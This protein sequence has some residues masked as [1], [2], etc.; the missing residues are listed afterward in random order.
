MTK[1][2]LE[3]TYR[4]ISQSGKM[5][6]S[7]RN[8]KALKRHRQVHEEVRESAYG[9]FTKA[10]AS[11]VAL[12]FAKKDKSE[13]TT[14]PKL[15]SKSRFARSNAIEVRTRS[16]ETVKSGVTV[17]RARATLPIIDSS[18]HQHIQAR[19]VADGERD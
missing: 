19:A 7:F 6:G 18:T 4:P 17:Q 2:E 8:K 9:D 14:F 11:L 13:K 1:K 12:F 15:R 5:A 16:I 10:V 3:A